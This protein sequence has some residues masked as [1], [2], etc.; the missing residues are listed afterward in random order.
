MVGGLTQVFPGG[1]RDPSTDVL[2]LPG[3]GSQGRLPAGTRTGPGPTVTR[4]PS[5]MGGRG[6]QT[7]KKEL[8]L[9]KLNPFLLED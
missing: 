9:Y 8:E 6:D 7:E 4:T 1:L 2:A 5:L 3:R